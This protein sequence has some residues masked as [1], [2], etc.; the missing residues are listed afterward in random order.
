MDVPRQLEGSVRYQ[1]GRWKARV[2]VEGRERL[3]PLEPPLV[4]PGARDAAKAATLDLQRRVVRPGE[5]VAE[6]SQRW[7]RARAARGLVGNAIRSHLTV[8]LLPAI[9]QRP[10]RDVGPS[11]IERIVEALDAKL[12]RGELHGKTPRHVWCTLCTMFDDARRSKILDLRV[13]DDDP[14]RAVRGP[15]RG[16]RTEHVVLYPDEFLRLVSCEAV[17]R[18]RRRAYAIAVYGYLRPAELEALRWDDIDLVHEIVHVRRSVG[19]ERQVAKAPKAGRARP[20]CSLEPALVPL[21]RAM[22]RP[23]GPVVGR[24]G[25]ERTVAAQL[26]ADLRTAG[27]DRKEL[28][29]CCDDPPR[30]WMTMHDLRRTGITWMAVRGDSIFT[31]LARAGHASADTTLHYVELGALVR[32]GHGEP[33]PVLPTELL[34]EDESGP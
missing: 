31:M 16:V 18:R 28:Y 27:V 23:S 19:R 10:M 32:P 21:L 29:T 4:D 12:A 3:V 9:G 2:L 1:G 17:P 34:R 30:R 25:N 20:P 7:V 6:W 8:H 13:R 26:R 33:F 11:E 24:L 22:H 15:E 5:T 14:T